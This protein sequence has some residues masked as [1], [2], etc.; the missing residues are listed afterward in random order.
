MYALYNAEHKVENVHLPLEK[1]DYGYSKRCAAYNFFA[2]HLKLNYRNIPYE[3][4]YKEDFVTVLPKE[5]LKI[6]TEENP[7]PADA[8]RGDQAVMKY[9]DIKYC[10]EKN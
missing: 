7:M 5:D 2:H 9:L 3:D 8:L 10:I 1:H 6:F 4:G